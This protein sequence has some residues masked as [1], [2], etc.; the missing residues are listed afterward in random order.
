MAQGDDAG[1]GQGGDVDDA[2][3]FETL[4]VG[5]GIA[6]NQPAFGIGIEDL[7]GLSRE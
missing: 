4:G 1:A 5:K 2:N 7:Y 6:K 3:R